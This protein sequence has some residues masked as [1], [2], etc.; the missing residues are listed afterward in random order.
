MGHHLHQVA[1]HFFADPSHESAA[2]SGNANHHL[3]AIFARARTHD[4]AEVLQ[5]IDQAARRG[6]GVTHFFRDGRHRQHFFLVESGEQEKLREGNVA[7]R[8]FLGKTQNE[9]ALHLQNDVGEPFGVGAKLIDP[10]DPRMRRR[11]QAA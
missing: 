4:I 7:R 9:T 8:Q 5:S 1:D 3:P 10:I 11:I 6:G 2:F